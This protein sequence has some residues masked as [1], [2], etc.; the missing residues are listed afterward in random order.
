M[1]ASRGDNPITTS[2]IPYICLYR[3]IYVNTYA[4]IRAG[5]VGEEG[6]GGGGEGVYL[7]IR[8]G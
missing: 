8:G 1:V 2:D 6:L 4:R 7:A 3:F 5:R